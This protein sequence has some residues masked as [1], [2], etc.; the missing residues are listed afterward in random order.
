MTVAYTLLSDLA[1]KVQPPDKDILS[2][3]LF[4][5]DRLHRR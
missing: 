2:C 5:D 1:K 3:T 4:N